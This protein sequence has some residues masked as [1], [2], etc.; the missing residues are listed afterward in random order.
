ME[1]VLIVLLVLL[2]GGGAHPRLFRAGLSA[3]D[4]AFV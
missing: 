1:A 2:L 4:R 3:R